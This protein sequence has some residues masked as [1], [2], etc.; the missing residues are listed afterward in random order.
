YKSSLLAT[1]DEAL[2]RIHWSASEYDAAGR[3]TGE[4]IDGIETVHRFDNRGHLRYLAANQ[5]LTK[6]QTLALE[7]DAAGNVTTRDDNLALVTEDFAYDSL[8]RLG[9]WTTFQNCRKSVTDFDY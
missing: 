9:T 4:N 2:S 5:G 6:L 1:V 8:G 3:L 7:Y